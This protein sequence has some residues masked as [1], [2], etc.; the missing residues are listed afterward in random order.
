[1][2]YV[3]I[4]QNAHTDDNLILS[5]SFDRI[6]QSD[7]ALSFSYSIL[8]RDIKPDGSTALEFQ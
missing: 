5:F 2:S 4:T 7:D 6:L 3:L 8:N 1:M